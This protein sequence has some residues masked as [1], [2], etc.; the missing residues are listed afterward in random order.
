MGHTGCDRDG[1]R[2]I[3]SPKLQP[4][5]VCKITSYPPEHKWGYIQLTKF[6]NTFPVGYHVEG[7]PYNYCLLGYFSVRVCDFVCSNF[8]GIAGC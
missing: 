1:V 4:F 2:W 5:G 3:H 8:N 7:F 6:R